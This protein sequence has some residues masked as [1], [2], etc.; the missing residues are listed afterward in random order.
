MSGY[1]RIKLP[2][3]T[4]VLDDSAPSAAAYLTFGVPYRRSSLSQDAPAVRVGRGVGCTAGKLESEQV[5]FLLL[6][7]HQLVD[8]SRGLYEM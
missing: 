1:Q 4:A 6:V 8:P 2:L 5:N 7:G 3:T